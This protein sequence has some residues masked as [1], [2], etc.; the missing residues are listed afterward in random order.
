MKD[1]DSSLPAM[2][3]ISRLKKVFTPEQSGRWILLSIAIGVISGFM[4]GIFFLCLEWCT[5]H[6]F[7][8]WVGMPMTVPEGERI[9][10]HVATDPTSA[11]RLLFFFLPV[12]GGL[13]S[14]WLVYTFA[15]E[16]EG[17]GTD[18][19]IR[20]FHH[21]KGKIRARVPPI[22]AVS[23]I[24]TLASGG[25]AGR[26]GPIAQIGAGLGSWLA[27]R[28]KLS[29]YER[30][31][32]LLAGTA[33]GLGAIF[34]APLGGAIT[35]IE[36]PYKEDFETDAMIPCVIA[37]VFAFAIFSSIFGFEHI[38]KIPPFVFRNPV[39]LVFYAILAAVCVPAGIFYIRS[40]E[41]MRTELFPSIPLP[42]HFKPMI[43][44]FGVALI[45][46]FVPAV[47]GAGWG[48]LQLAILGK[49]TIGTM[50]L[51]GVLKI[52][53]TSLTIG[54]GGSGG[55]FGPTLFIGGMLGGAVGF[56][57][58]HF[59]PSIV[60]QPGA[61]VLVGMAAFFA[62]VANAPLGALLMT[63][64][65]TGGY[66]LLP[67][68]MLVSILA[69]FF[70]KK[71]SIYENQKPN[72]FHSP[73]HIGDFTINILAEMKVGDLLPQIARDDIILV[74]NS[75]NFRRF[76]ELIS[77]TSR[78]CFPVI[79]G[80]NHLTGLISLK[81]TRSIIFEE[82]LRDLILAQDLATPLVTLSPAD[83][84]HDALIR[85]L[86]SDYEEIPI[87]DAD[88]RDHVLGM[89]RHE[90]IISAYHKEIVRRRKESAM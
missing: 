81:N 6:A 86:E 79:D 42:R 41:W 26:E 56:L 39:E 69:L 52:V 16:A 46:L 11:N 71:W 36:V 76:Q 49:V 84:L 48:Q 8:V 12:I 31:I 10:E 77:G 50:L 17:H 20:A 65:M 24:L 53:A 22:K 87:V 3:A 43:G 13:L 75:L 7:E 19:M 57:G 88:D 2:P 35:A 30:R 33:A 44:G 37:S 47:Y 27:D 34:R 64:E 62:G 9:F 45:G 1:S 54:S 90:D 29:A 63:C 70:S 59:F 72:K 85:F 21:E 25:S 74:R 4:A 68:L 82:S 38:F 40:F 14:G 51:L 67:P 61:Y 73:A 80:E 66:D 23:T 83:S 5:H 58:H 32:M 60:S 28:L 55:V 89:I 18:A 78:L 15:P